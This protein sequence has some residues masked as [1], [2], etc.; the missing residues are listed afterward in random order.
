MGLPW[1]RCSGQGPHP[2]KTLEPR[3]FSRV[4]S[5]FSKTTGISGFLLC[6]P[7]EANL[8]LELRGK[9]GDSARVTTGPKRA[10]RGVCPGPNI[11]LKGRQRSRVS[12]PDSP[13]ESGLASRGSRGL[14]FPLKSQHGS[15]GAH[16]VDS[17]VS[18]LLFS[19]ERGLGIAL[20]VRQEKKALI[21]R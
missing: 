3:R 19:L 18:S 21:S 16:L 17:R 8:P 11:P 9:A 1:R 15:L 4:A 20:Q 2:V 12:I 7:W 5:G 6:W 14:H 10:H 13:G